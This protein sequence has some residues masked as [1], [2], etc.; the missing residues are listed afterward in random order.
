MPA[1]IVA[2]IVGIICL[3][4]YY[5]KSI[6]HTMSYDERSDV[7]YKVLLKESA[8][9][10]SSYNILM[11]P[12]PSVTAENTTR[13]RLLEVLANNIAIRLGVYFKNEKQ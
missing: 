7:D 4:V 3:I 1:F 12:Y 10:T 9:S 11:L 5:N 6:N 8:F 2:F 13:K